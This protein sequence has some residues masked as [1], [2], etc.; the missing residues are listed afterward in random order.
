MMKVSLPASSSDPGMSDD[1]ATLH[2]MGYA[3]ELA[4]R[5]GAFQNFALSFSIICVL[6]GCLTAYQ[7][8]FSA[9]G[10]FSIGVGWPVGCG[11]AL[12]CAAS[13]GQIASAY[14]TAGG[15]YHWGSILG[16]K[17]LGWAAAWFNMLGLVFGVGANSVGAYTL[18]VNLL[19]PMFGIDPTPY[20][21]FWPQ[22]VAILI[23][24]GSLGL[25]NHIGIRVTTLLTDFSGYLIFTVTVVLTVTLFIAA[26]HIDLT[27]LWK[28]HNYTGDVGGDVW[29]AASGA[30][31][32]FMLGF[33]QVCYTVAGY[34]ASAHTSEE[35]KNAAREVPRGMIRAV[36]WSF[37]FG[38]LLLV[39]ILMATPNLDQAAQ[40][41]GNVVFWV[42]NGASIWH[43]LRI[44]LYVGV[45][46]ANYLC[47]LATVTALSRMIFAFA[48][49][50]GMPFSKK[51][52]FVSPRFRTPVNAVW[53]ACVLGLI[54]T[55][56]APAFAV[57]ASACAVLLYLSYALPIGAGLFA[58]GRSWTQKGPFNLKGFSKPIAVGATLGA[59]LLAWVGTRPP[60]DKVGYVVFGLSIVLVL[61][62]YAGERTRFKGPPIGEAV[63][64]GRMNE[65]LVEEAGVE[66]RAA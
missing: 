21:S 24:I 65:I 55:L 59:L 36:W 35:T 3:Q 34:D 6:A 17:G 32:V 46:I 25:F 28:Y 54:S 48:R 61:V 19:L 64:A 37:V 29:P 42:L 53:L 50:G 31:Y 39:G 44:F 20:T 30:V 33:L 2:R 16:G 10:G 40:Q 1:V 15:L 56:Y 43:W 51:L 27:R 23:L 22:L 5:M 8:A 12:L 11:F 38:Y 49:D 52:R 7:L 4:R 45:V 66:E 9:G 41:G 57:L 58:E 14:P 26:P 62:W 13:M 47:C 60:N 63:I 18:G